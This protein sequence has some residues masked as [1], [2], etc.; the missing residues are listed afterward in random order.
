MADVTLSGRYRLVE[1]LG[2][3]GMAIVWRGYDEVLGRQVAVKVPSLELAANEAFLQRLRAEAQATARL[4]H[5]HITAVHDY[6]ES[7][8]EEGRLQPYVVMELVEGV[9]LHDVLAGGRELPWREAAT[10]AAQVCMALAEAH[11]RGI[12]H[13]DVSSCN[14][15]L[16]ATGVKVLD[17]GIAALIGEHDSAEPDRL[18]GTPAY[19]APERLRE[20]DV[21]A[22]VDVYAV[23][24]LLYRMLRGAFP[25][26]V[27]TPTALLE[28]HLRL[29][30]P[31][32]AKLPGLPQ[33]L[34][35]LCHRCLAKDPADRPTSAE[36]AARLGKM[37]GLRRSKALLEVPRSAEPAVRTTV[38]PWQTTPS[39]PVPAK[40]LAVTQARRTALSTT[41]PPGALLAE[42]LVAHGS[43]RRMAVLGGLGLVAVLA[44]WLLSGGGHAPANNRWAAP[45]QAATQ[46]HVTYQVTRDDGSR[47]EAAITI[48]NGAAAQQPTRLGF[49]WPG[50]QK[51]LAADAATWKQTGR[52]VV[53]ETQPGAT[54]VALEGSYGSLNPLPAEFTWN[55]TACSAT[56]LGVPA[57]VV[58]VKQAA[59]PAPGPSGKP[60]KGHGGKGRGDDDE[61]DDDEDG[62]D[63]GRSG[64]G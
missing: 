42:P 25:W 18:L 15:M 1:Q 22:A 55:G 47:F 31:P 57:D 39:T 16:T 19:V 38:L 4:S 10:V 62:D 2:S 43:P 35:D 63:G 46:C 3:G 33:G 20:N 41:P 44:A 60:D 32:L 52:D 21:T 37:A 59:G 5:P 53:V 51:V 30:P 6:G 9:T 61:D 24:I 12:V 13:R 54:S 56:V 50:D 58:Q 28:A 49:P 27:E 26:P 40:P 11:E 64:P 45:A 48:Q 17:F 14:V 7:L 34:V 29:E 8:S 36:L 23:G